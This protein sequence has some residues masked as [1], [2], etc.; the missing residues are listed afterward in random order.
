MT[1]GPHAAPRAISDSPLMKAG[2]CAI[3]Q[4][5]PGLSSKAD[6]LEESRLCLD[7]A[8]SSAVAESDGEERRG[9]TPAR[10]FVS[11]GGGQRLAAFYLNPELAEFLSRICN[12]P[13]RP[14]GDSGTFTY[15]ARPGDH[16]ALHRDIDTCDLAV[17]TCLLDRHREGSSGGLTRYYPARQ[18]EPLSRIRATPT[19][20]AVSVRLP[21]GHTMVMFGG[22]VPHLIVPLAAGELRVVAL[23]CFRVLAD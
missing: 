20:G 21:V 1:A 4:G 2:G 16:L 7:R 17:I 8:V 22:L 6:L 11:A 14:S 23:L 12:A 18:H 5:L 3:Y 19:H 10:R 13:V 15:Y 9:G